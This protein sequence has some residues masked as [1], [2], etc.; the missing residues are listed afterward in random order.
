[1]ETALLQ[2]SVKEK[3]KVSGISLPVS[4]QVA[5]ECLMNIYKKH[6][7]QL[8]PEVLVDEAKSKNHPLH[9]CFEWNDTKAGKMW[10]LHQARNIIRCVVVEKQVDDD[11]K[12]EVR[13]FINVK[14]D[15]NNH[16]THNPFFKG[17]SFYVSLNDAMTNEHLRKYTVE[18][19]IGELNNWMDKYKGVKELADLFG[20]IEKKT[21]KYKKARV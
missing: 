4:P 10:R 5:G 14:K 21:I 19:A 9:D 6:D 3:F 18:M 12:I 11:K 2:R 20:I 1:M 8:T 13:A 17:E 15:E 7:C 16:L